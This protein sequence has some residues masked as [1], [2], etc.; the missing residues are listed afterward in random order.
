MD[1]EFSLFRMTF[2]SQLSTDYCP[3]HMYTDTNTFCHKKGMLEGA[4]RWFSSGEKKQ[5]TGEDEKAQICLENENMLTFPSFRTPDSNDMLLYGTNPQHLFYQSSSMTDLL[6]TT[7]TIKPL[8]STPLTLPPRV[9][10]SGS[11]HHHPKPPSRSTSTSHWI[12]YP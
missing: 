12:A 11:C 8:T 6:L 7:F 9:S 3:I 4:V 1:K 2:Q 5:K 10:S